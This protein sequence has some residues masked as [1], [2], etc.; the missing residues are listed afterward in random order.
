MLL[1]TLII[2]VLAGLMHLIFVIFLKKF[3]VIPAN[4]VVIHILLL[5]WGECVRL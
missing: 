5:F 4:L 1:L 3:I 2:A